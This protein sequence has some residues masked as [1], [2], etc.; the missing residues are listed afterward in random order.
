MRRAGRDVDVVSRCQE[1]S[2][3]SKCERNN[4]VD[5]KECLMQGVVLVHR[6]CSAL[7]SGENRAGRRLSQLIR[8]G[9][10]R[11]KVGPES[12]TKPFARVEF[13]WRLTA[14]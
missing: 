1:V 13:V 2:L 7:C 6:K 4:A 9:N 8:A 3:A 12:V 5:D 10:N 11:G 14:W